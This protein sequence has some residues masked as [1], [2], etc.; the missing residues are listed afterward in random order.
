MSSGIRRRI[1]A[2]TAGI[3]AAAA[4]AIAATPLTGT[5]QAHSA[6][7][8]SLNFNGEPGEPI[9]GGQ[10]YEYTADT[11]QLFDAGGGTDENGFIVAVD[12]TEGTLWRLLISAPEGQK[13]TAGTT[14]TGAK[15]WPDIQPGDPGLEFG[16]I[17]NGTEK[18]CNTTSGSFTIENIAFGPYGY[19]KELDAT[20]EQYCDG[21]TVPLRGEVHAIMPEPPVEL[22]IGMNLDTTGS[23]D[24]TGTITVGGDVTCN[25]PARFALRVSAY[26]IQK[27]ATAS[28]VAGEDAFFVD[29]TPGAP[30]PWTVSFPS[31]LEPDAT[32]KSG[33]AV[34]RARGE[35][36]DRDYP[37]TQRTG[38]L[39]SEIT[40]VKS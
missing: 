8:G 18:A 38:D 26:Q 21:S 13:L 4:L 23:V 29:C 2:R 35:T 7:S 36:N 39:S 1:L 20:F 24:K 40:L 10:S 14:Y 32:F 33:P 15:K 11:V 19:V 25:K 31:N 27:N 22:A 5:A 17:D 34:L 37:V 6:V 28:G 12:A 9:S 3:V 16:G 30:V